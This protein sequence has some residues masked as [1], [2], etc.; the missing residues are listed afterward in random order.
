MGRGLN[1]ALT[2]HM[3]SLNDGSCEELSYACTTNQYQTANPNLLNPL[4]PGPGTLLNA[5]RWQRLELTE[6]IDQ[7][8]IP[9]LNLYVSC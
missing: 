7:S 9:S 5:S 4:I 8:G 6:F 2:Y 1:V 3:Q